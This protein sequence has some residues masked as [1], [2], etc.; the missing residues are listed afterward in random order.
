[1]TTKSGGWPPRIR[2]EVPAAAVRRGDGD[3]VLA[4]LRDYARITKDSMAGLTGEALAPRNWQEKLI[5]ETFARDPETGRR[6]H[7]TALWGM[8]RKNGKTGLVAPIGLFGLLLEGQGAEVYSCAADRDQARLIFN[9]AVR[10]V[11]LVPELAERC[12][13][14]RSSHTIED[15]ASG[16]IYRALSSE[17]YTKEGLS[18][19]LVLADELHAWPTRELYDVMALAMGA[20]RDPLMLIVTT[21]GIRTDS[22][23]QDSIAYSLWQYGRRVAS[24]EVVDPTFYLAWWAAEE[25]AE[26]DSETAQRDANPG[27]GEILDATELASAAQKALMGGFTESEFRIKRLNQW[28]SASHAAIPSGAWARLSRQENLA[29]GERVVLFLDGSYSG[30]S[31]GLVACTMDGFIDVVDAWERPPDDP[32]W[33]VDIAAVEKAVLDACKQYDVIEVDCDPFRWQRSIQAL[34]DAGAPVVEYNTASPARM[35][36]A[37]ARFYDA[38]TAGVG[39]THSGDPRLARHVDNMSLKVDHLGPRPV[40]EH[41][42][43]PRKIDL[44]I[45]AVGAYDRATTLSSIPPPRPRAKLFIGVT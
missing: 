41:K 36:P 33:R 13:V 44:G 42:G 37:W 14:Y 2:T 9:A 29:P 28:V 45:C 3:D 11:E 24:G 35:V 26:I 23:G 39:I 6:R 43:S 16:S 25:Q 34:Q 19:T 20:R 22:T 12:K 4:F 40:K 7:R 21:A 32:H 17:A 8:G 15:P 1:M 10:T 18:P 38:V 31:T 30:D 5:L 27:Y